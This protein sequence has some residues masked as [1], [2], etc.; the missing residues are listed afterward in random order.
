MS[1]NKTT[2]IVENNEVNNK[3]LEFELPINGATGYAPTKIN[4]LES[5]KKDAEILTTISAG[6]AFTIISEDGNYLYAQYDG[7]LGFLDSTLCMINLPDIIPS[8][9]YDNTNSYSSIFKSSGY[10]LD[11][12]TGKQLYDASSYNNRFSEEEYSMPV[13]YQMAKKIYQAQKN[14][15]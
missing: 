7:K 12:I 4:L 13:I 1:E 10:N 8:I 5:A 9:V 3:N 2:N 15:T 14:G 6:N 11:G